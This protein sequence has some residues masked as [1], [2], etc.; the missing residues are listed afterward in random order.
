M[1][2]LILS[3]YFPPD[4]SAG[5]FR[6]SALVD[7]LLE[8]LPE[9]VHLEVITTQPNRYGSYVTDAPLVETRPRLTIHRIPLP[10]HRSGMLDQSR[11]FLAYA[12][13]ALS[14]V[15]GRRY[16]MVY[17]TSSR[18]MTASVGALI[19]RRRKLPL[20][21]D[22][23][24]IFV[25]T[26]KDVLSRKA[27]LILRP[28]F[29][30]IESWTV[31][32]ATRVNLVS[33]GFLPYFQDRY[34][35]GAYSL[36]TNGI[37][38]E[39]IAAQPVASD[40]VNDAPGI[41]R[42]VYAGNIGEGQGLHAIVPALAKRLQGRVEF[43]I[44][45]DGG[46]RDALQGALDAVGCKNV[47]LLPPVKRDALIEVYRSADVLFLHL[48][49][50]DAFRKVLPSKIFEYAALGKPIWAGVAGFSAQFIVEHVDNAGV[51]APCD[52]DAAVLALSQLE[53][54]TRPRT[55]FVARFSRDAIMQR[56]AADVASVIAHD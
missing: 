31:T 28:L 17:A 30:L 12:R 5:S 11:S 34:P 18:L 22:I 6:T 1:R 44:V 8:S 48:N 27:G 2:I 41:I 29:S 54:A 24:D 45:G 7:A 32:A 43:V 14:I 53:I 35:G 38:E 42:V 36:F 55:S 10:S 49:D 46:R 23:R 4:L 52:V 47:Q 13:G 50:Y 37:D 33:G 3:F 51:F 16:D 40:P 39:F 15:R 26:I 25:D 19:A 20:Y 21:L 9:D 56:M